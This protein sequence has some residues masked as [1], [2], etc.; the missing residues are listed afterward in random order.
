[1]SVY[2]N[3]RAGLAI[4]ERYEHYPRMTARHDEIY[5]GPDPES[6]SDEDRATLESLGWFESDEDCFMWMT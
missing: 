2:E 1:M 4:F 6:V 3:F 5:A